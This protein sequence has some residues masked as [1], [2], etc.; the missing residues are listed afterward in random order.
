MSLSEQE[1]ARRCAWCR[2]PLGEEGTI[3]DGSPICF[4]CLVSEAGKGFERRWSPKQEPLPPEQRF[5]ALFGAARVLLREGIGEEDQ[6]FPTLVFAA[7]LG[8]GYIDLETSKKRLLAAQHSP[9]RWEIEADRFVRACPRFR[10]IDVVEGVPILERLPV[11]VE[12]TNYMHP[13]IV[14]P[15]R[16]RLEVTPS[17]YMVKPEHIAALYEKALSAAGIPCTEGTQGSMDFKYTEDF[18]NRLLITL[19]HPLE[20]I[21]DEGIAPLEELVSI[22]PEGKPPFPHPLVV[23]GF[24]EMLMG[25][26][27]GHHGFAR[28]LVGRSRGRTPDADTL[29]PATVAAY[30][31]RLGKISSRIEVHR[32]LNAHVLGGTWKTLPEEGYASSAV[33]QLWRDVE[34]VKNWTLLDE[35][36]LFC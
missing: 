14:I 31:R 19:K 23:Q 18:G 5:E 3:E 15:K 17:R 4:D 22:Y 8:E 35:L 36:H 30:L 32:L 11:H 13:E 24:Y 28:Y 26:P 27:R 29:V 20:D 6:V 2:E 9:Q 34:K 1:K 16:V 12:I 25:T 7:G 33:N 10:P 21:V